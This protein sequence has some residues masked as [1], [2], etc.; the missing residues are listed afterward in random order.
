MAV[1]SLDGV[2]VD[3]VSDRTFPDAPRRQDPGNRANPIKTRAR[4]SMAIDE[5]IDRRWS[6]TIKGNAVAVTSDGTAVLGLGD[7]SPQAAMPVMEGKAPLFKGFA[8]VDAFRC[9]WPRQD[10]ESIVGTP[11]GQVRRKR[12]LISKQCGAEM[13]SRLIA[14]KVGATALTNS[15]DDQHRT[16]NVVLAVLT[17]AVWVVE[18]RA[19]EVKV[20]VVAP[21]LQAWPVPRSC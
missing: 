19:A 3:G 12:R 20:V 17:N 13:S 7:I 15:N 16:A 10:T 5:D 8:G 9:A 6:L 1:R 4:V 11:D 14:Q 21:A 2:S 18:K